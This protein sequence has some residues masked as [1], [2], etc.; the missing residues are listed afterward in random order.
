MWSL[1]CPVLCCRSSG[2]GDS[3]E[4]PGGIMP[5][6]PAASPWRDSSHTSG[7]LATRRKGGVSHG[8]R[9]VHRIRLEPSPGNRGWNKRRRCVMLPAGLS[10]D[11]AALESKPGRV[12]AE[13]GSAAG[14]SA[15]RVKPLP[16]LLSLSTPTFAGR[17]LLEHPSCLG[18]LDAVP[19]SARLSKRSRK[20]VYST[21][22]LERRTRRDS[23]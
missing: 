6:T 16:L 13:V 11:E 22:A 8:L 2:G 14:P 7:E 12:R 3:A 18:F 17:P 20:M 9:F 23:D 5:V 21:C 15:A 10:K 19:V 1:S 4:Q